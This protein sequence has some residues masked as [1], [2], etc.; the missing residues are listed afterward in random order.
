MIDELIFKPT[1]L[2]VYIYMSSWKNPNS[3]NANY[4]CPSKIYVVH[5]GSRNPSEASTECQSRGEELAIFKTQKD[6][7]NFLQGKTY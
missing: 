2:Y 3:V 5:Q 1:S 7:T 4:N 6:Y